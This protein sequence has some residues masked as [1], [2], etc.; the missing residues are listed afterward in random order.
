[1]FLHIHLIYCKY[2]GNISFN[3]LLLIS[4]QRFLSNLLQ[5]LGSRE[6]FLKSLTSL[7]FNS[8]GVMIGELLK[9][10]VS[11][12]YL[13][14]AA[15]NLLHLH[16]ISPV[17]LAFINQKMHVLGILLSFRCSYYL[18]NVLLSALCEF[19]GFAHAVYFPDAVLVIASVVIMS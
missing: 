5:I 14:S 13:S 17:S 11:S 2:T 1:M 18:L 12:F 8:V 3:F 16:S 15:D 6:G 7:K 4:I 19:K 10:L 9:I